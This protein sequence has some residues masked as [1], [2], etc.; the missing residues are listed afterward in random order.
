MHDFKNTAL[1]SQ[2]R[3]LQS[4]FPLQARTRFPHTKLRYVE[5]NAAM[6]PPSAALRL[7]PMGADSRRRR[8]SEDV[9]ILAAL[10]AWAMCNLAGIVVLLRVVGEYSAVVGHWLP[11]LPRPPPPL[12]P[13]LPPCSP[14]CVRPGL[15]RRSPAG[16]PRD[17]Q[18]WREEEG[19]GLEGHCTGLRGQE[20][21]CG[22]V[23]AARADCLGGCRRPAGVAGAR[24]RC[25]CMYMQP[26]LATTRPR[27]IRVDGAG[28]GATEPA[29][30]AS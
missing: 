22:G 9:R 7:Q 1:R 6:P 5:P 12:R 26:A 11:P 17:R 13:P 2:W 30:P 14:P 20:S 8:H 3:A 16:A 18:G 24:A 19:G 4:P 23:C 10:T 29:S 27:R 25:A 15:A 28:A 21:T